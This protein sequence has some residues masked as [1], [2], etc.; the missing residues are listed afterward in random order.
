MGEKCGWGRGQA[1]QAAKGGEGRVIEGAVAAGAVDIQRDDGAV[2]VDRQRDKHAAF[3][4]Q[5]A[6][7]L[8]I[9]V[10]ASDVGDEALEVG[11]AQRVGVFV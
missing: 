4:P 7:V 10:A 3:Q 9:E 6:S 5:A 1:R 8:R 11:R 2:G